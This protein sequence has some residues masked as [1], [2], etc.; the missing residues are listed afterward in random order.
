MAIKRTHLISSL[1]HIYRPSSLFIDHPL[2]WPS[3]LSSASSRD[4]SSAHRLFCSSRI[5]DSSFRYLFVSLQWLR[6][7]LVRPQQSLS[8]IILL[9]TPQAQP[10]ILFLFSHVASQI[11]ERPRLALIYTAACTISYLTFISLDRKFRSS[12]LHRT[13]RIRPAIGKQIWH[14]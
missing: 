13:K 1:I 5:A 7:H 9:F 14:L 3:S 4:H 6:D 2:Y 8:V 10:Q 11:A 12:H